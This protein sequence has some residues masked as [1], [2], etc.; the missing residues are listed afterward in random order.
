MRLQGAYAYHFSLLAAVYLTP[1]MNPELGSV[2]VFLLRLLIGVLDMFIV[3]IFCSKPPTVTWY[4]IYYFLIRSTVP[5][6]QHFC[7]KTKPEID[8]INN[9]KPEQ[10]HSN[11]KGWDKLNWVKRQEEKINEMPLILCLTVKTPR[12]LDINTIKMKVLNNAP[13]NYRNG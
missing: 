2:K 10:M 4:F 9:R 11:W 1:E 12:N 13:W 7:R 3:P 6:S 5:L 8:E